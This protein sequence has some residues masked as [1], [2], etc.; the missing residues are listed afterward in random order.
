MVVSCEKLP[1]ADNTVTLQLG[2]FKSQTMSSL[3]SFE[4]EWKKKYVRDRILLQKTIQFNA[5]CQNGLKRE[6]QKICDH[7]GSIAIM[8]VYGS[9]S[10]T[11]Y[12]A[13]VFF[14]KMNKYVCVRVVSFSF[15]CCWYLFH[16]MEEKRREYL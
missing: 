3:V 4:W 6:L 5:W 15:C 11:C 16:S 8:L 10:Q 1:T 12:F 2:H 13:Q 7:T 14:H 9:S